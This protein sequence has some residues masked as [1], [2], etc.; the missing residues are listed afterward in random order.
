[1][2][3]RTALRWIGRVGTG[4]VALVVLA[5]GTVYA[6]SERRFRAHFDVPQHALAV[7][8]DPAAV[9]RGGHLVKVR[10]CI[11]CH[12]EKLEGHVELDDPA[13]GRLAGPNLTRGG[14]G[15]ALSDADWERA[16]RHGVRRDG[17]PLFVMPAIEHTGLSDED[18]GAMVAYARSVAPEPNVPPPSRAGPIIRGL[19]VANQ[20]QILSAEQIDHAKPHPA[21]VTPEPTVAYGGYLASMCTGC[22][23]A[24]FSGGKI[25][26]AP[27]DWPP[28]ANLTRAGSLGRWS[29][30]DFARLLRTGHRPD[31]SMVDT[32]HMAIRITKHL[33]DTEVQALYGFLRSLPERAYGS[34]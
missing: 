16:V 29:E 13:I 5:V 23:G 26:G 19:F 14:R 9:A 3:M 33:D 6:L 4:V 2:R 15:A 32:A 8:D 28:A 27:P 18:L 24:G 34:R 7:P 17:S 1:M 10:G 11:G 25:V 30:A 12:G 21:R 20:A 31:G 22:H